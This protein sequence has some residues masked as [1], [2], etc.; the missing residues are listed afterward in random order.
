MGFGNGVVAVAENGFDVYSDGVGEWGT[1][2]EATLVFEEVTGDFDKKLRVEFQDSSSQSRAGLIAR[3]VTNIGVDIATQDA[4]AAGRYQKVHV[5]PVTTVMGT[6]GNNSWEGNRRMVTGGPTDTAGG[7]G[8]PS[9][10]TPGAACNASARLFR[11]TAATTAPPG[12]LT[13]RP[14]GRPPRTPTTN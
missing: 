1:H 10:R 5:N 12:H 8:T 14:H 9:T 4:G 13:G 7:G 3:D 11:S 2:D 6:A